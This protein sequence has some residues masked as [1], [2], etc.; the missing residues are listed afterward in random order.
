MTGLRA[1][2]FANSVMRGAPRC[3]AT[4]PNGV[5]AR[6]I[7]LCSGLSGVPL[8]EA[9]VR[10]TATLTAERFHSRRQR[11]MRKAAFRRRGT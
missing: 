6:L 4:V 8:E 2:F 5:D 1:E 10:L 9:S 11:I 7:R 3:V